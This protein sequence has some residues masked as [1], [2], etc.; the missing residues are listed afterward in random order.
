M[1]RAGFRRVHI[2]RSRGSTGPLSPCLR[3]HRSARPTCPKRATSQ[4]KQL[5]Y[6]AMARASRDARACGRALVHLAPLGPRARA[7]ALTPATSTATWPAAPALVPTGRP[8]SAAASASASTCS[9]CATHF[10]TARGARRAVR[11]PARADT[12]PPARTLGVLDVR[13]AVAVF[14]ALKAHVAEVEDGGEQGEGEVLVAHAQTNHGHGALEA[15]ADTADAVR[16]EAA[17]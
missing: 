5:W 2:L 12:G 14:G 16:Q 9:R 10:D 13:L 4:R 15:H 3:A 1:R 17:M 7:R 6:S 8:T 11:A